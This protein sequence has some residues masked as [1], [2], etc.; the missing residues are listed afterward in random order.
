MEKNDYEESIKK[1]E[2]LLKKIEDPGTSLSDI[3]GDVKEAK[4]LID[5]CKAMLH[6]TE[7]DLDK[8]LKGDSDHAEGEEDAETTKVYGRQPDDDKNLPF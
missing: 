4:K 2:E 6:A 1:L 3:A 7:E 8:S 5:K